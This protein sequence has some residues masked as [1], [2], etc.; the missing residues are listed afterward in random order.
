MMNDLMT[1]AVVYDNV[2]AVESSSHVI[3]LL[4]FVYAHIV[5]APF[6]GYSEFTLSVQAEL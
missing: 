4:H 3:L 5:I 2:I 6:S 1:A